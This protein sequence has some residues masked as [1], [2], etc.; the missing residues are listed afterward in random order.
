M[1]TILLSTLVL[2]PA[3]ASLTIDEKV[4]NIS[5][6]ITSFNF[7]RKNTKGYEEYRYEK[8]STIFVKIPAGEFWMGSCPGNGEEDEHP[9]H[10]VNLDEYYI[11][12]YEVTNEQFEK[13]I[14]ETGYKTD[15]E[16]N[17]YGF[18]YNGYK[19]ESK[20]NVNWRYYYSKSRERHP[21]VMISWNDAKAYCDWAGLQ[22]PTEAE[23][24]KAARGTN[25]RE[26]PWGNEWSPSKCAAL[27]T[28]IGLLRSKPGY[29]DMGG[30]H[31]TIPVG[32]FIDGVSPYGCYDM[33]G[34]AWEWCADRYDSCYYSSSQYC[35]P[36]GPL[37]GGYH[38]LRGGSWQAVSWNCRSAFRIWSVPHFQR[39]IYGFRVAYSL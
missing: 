34:N 11:A 39:S 22:L 19:W 25:E 16:K 13:F 30:G 33:A 7:F 1:I 27:G 29:M 2:F 10:K 4:E 23:W 5:F 12:K 17:E 37:T 31:S 20:T 15:A 18:V 6:S 21:V 24:E 9:Q 3:R 32:H 38:V 8:D 35:N 36:T 14:I 28:D 26:Y